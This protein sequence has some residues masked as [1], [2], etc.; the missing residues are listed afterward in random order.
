[1]P[2]AAPM[3]VEEA[4]DSY[5]WC[6][7]SAVQRSMLTVHAGNG[8]QIL[9]RSQPSGYVAQVRGVAVSLGRRLRSR[10]RCR[11]YG[12]SQVPI[13]EARARAVQSVHVLFA[14]VRKRML[15]GLHAVRQQDTCSTANRE[16]D[17]AACTTSGTH[18]CAA[19]KKIDSQP[20]C[21]PAP[22]T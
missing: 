6:S 3:P 10:F 21:T 12:V 7:A 18:P 9:G 17:R 2:Q 4:P 13:R 11:V 5:A 15:R 16:R 22:S 19:S 20:A 14:R 1:M 8:H